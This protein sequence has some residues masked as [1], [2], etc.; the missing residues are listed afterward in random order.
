MNDAQIAS[1][2][3]AVA[4]KTSKV[5]WNPDSDTA[6]QIVRVGTHAEENDNTILCGIFS[7]GQYVAL[8]NCDFNDFVVTRPLFT[9]EGQLS[10]APANWMM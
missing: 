7:N 8:Y 3:D 10:P 2:K 4:S 6:R 1:L 5:M 9:T